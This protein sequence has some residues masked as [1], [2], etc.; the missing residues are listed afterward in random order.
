M[1]RPE[2][3]PPT[4]NG[5]GASCIALP[6]GNWPTILAFLEERFPTL[7]QAEIVRR[8]QAGHVMDA[9]G[10]A[11][12]P[13]EPYQP[14]R[15][16]YYYRH[17]VD[18][19]AIP[20]SEQILFQDDYLVAVD[21]PHFLPVS[22]VG[23]Y[24]QETLLVRLKRK[25]GT[26][27]LA[28]MHRLDR[29]TAGVMVFTLQPDLRGKYQ[30]LFMARSVG[31]VYEAVAPFRDDLTFPMTLRSHIA[32][33]DSFMRVRLDEARAHEPNAETL[34]ELIE[35]NGQW[36]RYRLRPNSG[37]KHQLRVQMAS[38]GLPIRH[39]SIYPV[40]HIH[41]GRDFSKPLQLLARRIAFDD[42]VTGQHRVFE[43]K[44]S[45]APLPTVD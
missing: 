6:P 8:M 4:R 37:K 7:T 33:G 14:H 29:E 1:S 25:L 40:H 10:G 41:A 11:I 38:L 45:L 3:I 42:P 31:K 13:Q 30:A 9:D 34:I 17:I 19:P 20:F 21:K 23:N 32:P 28:P 16:V 35:H 36:A 39:D 15:K 22:P 24:V 27:S 12:S 2:R 43:S 26:D 18:E 44:R 5:V